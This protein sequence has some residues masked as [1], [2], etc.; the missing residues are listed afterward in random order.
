[1]CEMADNT[2][3]AAE[4]VS[5]SSAVYDTTPVKTPLGGGVII[6]TTEELRYG[7]DAVILSH[8]AGVKNRDTVCDLGCGGGIIPMILGR[9]KQGK[10]IYAVDIQTAA[11]ELSARASE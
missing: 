2:K 8:F 5:T 3:T 9:N 1:M 11:C 6:Y 7:T 4:K 10:K